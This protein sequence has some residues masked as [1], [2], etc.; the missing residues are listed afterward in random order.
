MKWYKRD[1]DA[2]LTGMRGLSDAEYK[3][4]GIIIDLLYSRDG[5]L[6][7]DEFLISVHVGWHRQKWRRVRSSLLAKGKIHL[8]T[9]GKL[10]ANRVQTAIKE[11]ANYSESQS[12]RAKSRWKSTSDTMPPAKPLQPQPHK[13]RKSP[14]GSKERTRAS[15]ARPRTTLPEGWLP[16]DFVESERALFD[17]FA[18]YCR[19]HAKLYADYQ[20]AW[21]NWKRR[22]PQFNNGGKHGRRHGSVL[23]ALD[24]IGESLEAA[25]ATN[26]YIPGS[27]GPKPLNLDQTMRPPSPK[28]VSSR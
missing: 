24:K 16:D 21:N 23:D 10:T 25:G 12:L 18:D 5:D 15:R 14:S 13:E 22:E 27:S 8:Q 11:A 4:Y 20:A 7:D 26:D 17:E 3:A 6:P 9:D 1:P 28:L 2:A 19:A